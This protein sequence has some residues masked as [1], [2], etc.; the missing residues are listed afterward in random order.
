MTE[1]QSLAQADVVPTLMA[2]HGDAIANARRKVE[3][4]EQALRELDK[5]TDM[6]AEHKVTGINADLGAV[7]NSARNARTAAL[8]DAERPGYELPRAAA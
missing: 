4:L 3:D 8:A 6:L 1:A 7:G 2:R 5:V